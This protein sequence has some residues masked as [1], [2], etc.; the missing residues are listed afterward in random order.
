MLEELKENIKRHY[1]NSDEDLKDLG[2]VMDALKDIET[3]DLLKSEL[4][5]AK[6][7]AEKALKDLDAEWRERYRARFFD[8]DAIAPELIDFEDKDEREPEEITIDE[9]IKEISKEN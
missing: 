2:E 1:G 4:E 3:L 9:Y 6:L 5:T 7:D 8:G